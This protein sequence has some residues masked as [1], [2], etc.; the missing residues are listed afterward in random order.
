MISVAAAVQS[1]PCSTNRVLVLCGPG[2]NGADGLV[3]ARH[4][5]QCHIG[6]TEC[7]VTVFFPKLATLTDSNHLYSR[8][9]LQ[10]NHE[11]VPIHTCYEKFFLEQT[12]GQLES[13]Y[14]VVVDALFGFGFKGVMRSPYKE[15]V[16]FLNQS[17]LPILSVD[18]PSGCNENKERTSVFVQKPFAL[19][20]LMAPKICVKNLFS[21]ASSNSCL[22]FLGQPM[23][24]K[25][26]ALQYGISN[27]HRSKTEHSLIIPLK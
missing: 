8:L 26:L 15:V 16:T 20:S 23:L 19:I 7:S 5:K 14:D 13:Q 17:K 22:H 25:T 24:P 3:A 4:L 1:L 12:E 6:N 9:V 18:V 27:V 11:E 21:N 10:L 2:N